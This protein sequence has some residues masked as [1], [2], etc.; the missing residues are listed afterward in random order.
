MVTFGVMAGKALWLPRAFLLPIHTFFRK[1]IVVILEE[2]GLSAVGILC[3]NEVN[4]NQKSVRYIRYL[5]ITDFGYNEVHRKNG[6][7]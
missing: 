6:K 4:G 5:A 3:F 7:S 1:S 2:C